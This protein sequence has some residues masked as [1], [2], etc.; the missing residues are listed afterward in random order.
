MSQEIMEKYVE[1]YN[2]TLIENTRILSMLKKYGIYENYIFENF[3]LGYSDGRLLERIDKNDELLKHFEEVGIIKNGKEVFKNYI[4]IPIYNE[5]KEIINIVGYN[6]Y[7]RS[8]NKIIMLNG[9]GVFNQ[10]FLQKAKEL[11]LTQ[12]P[13]EVLL[14]IQN[15]YPNTTFLF[16]EDSKYVKFIN[17]N[18]I[19]RVIFAFEGKMR[20]FYELS[21]N[22]VSTKRVVVDYNKAKEPGAKEYLDI[23]FSGKTN[24]NEKDQSSDIIQEIENGFLF[25]FPHLNYKVIGNFTEYT[26]NMKANIKVYTKEDVFVDQIDLYKNRDRLNFIYNIMD[27]FNIRDQIQLENDLTQII[28]VIEKHKEKKEKEKKKTKPVLTEYQKDIGLS[29]LKNPNLIDEIEKDYERLGYVRERKNKILLYLVMTSRL[30]DNPLHAILISRSG[31]GK[32]LLAEITESLCP[33]EELES[34]SDLSAQAL[35]YY[36]KDDLKHRF[37]VIGEKEGSEGSD[38]PLRELITKKSI[39]KAIPMKDPLTGQIKTVNIKVEGPIAFVETTTSSNINPENL[40]RCFVISI[41]ES[42][43]QTRLI[44]QI[45]RKNYTIEGYLQK[46]DLDKIR[47]KHIYAQRI[48]KK[49]RVFNPY[50]ELLSFPSSKLKTR[51]DNEK[52]LRL[53]NVITFLHQYQRKVKKLKLENNEVIEYI[54]CTPYD[55]RIAYELLSDGVLDNTLDDL[56][57]PARKLLELIKKY[58]RERSD[59]DNIP[60]DKIIF[61]RRDIREYTSWSFAQIRN[62]FRILQDYEYLQLIKSKNGTA[63]QYKLSSNYSDIDFLNKILSPEEL[64]ERISQQKQRSNLNRLNIPEHLGE[65]VLIS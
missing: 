55:Y 63:K 13:L 64:E 8:K 31:A 2:K 41:D 49:I 39:T 1:I 65:K 38:Y 30:M 51:R 17:D 29:F 58:L 14:L 12:S 36:G 5:K 10:S 4:T 44:H 6:I 25:Q 54:E 20:L 45:Q 28:E 33:P 19:K 50:A 61:E 15:D 24:K 53:I 52:F 9:S 56:P 21:K 59:R 48:L 34:I 7:S 18:N 3:L 32:S 35:Y 60:V 57:R 47:S 37:I 62:N 22:G 42:E 23:L 26:M 16:G 11:I 46:R 40:N 43:D 27:K